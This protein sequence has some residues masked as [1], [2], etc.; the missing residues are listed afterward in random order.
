M[1]Y[2]ILHEKFI[3]DLK[4]P[5]TSQNKAALIIPPGAQDQRQW[6][7]EPPQTQETVA[8]WAQEGL[9]EPSRWRSGRGGGEDTLI[10]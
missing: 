9:E 8:A 5:I 4:F 7:E 6:L 3:F 2:T 10:R 1:L